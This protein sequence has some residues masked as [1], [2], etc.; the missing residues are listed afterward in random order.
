MRTA[1]RSTTNTRTTARRASSMPPQVCPQSLAIMQC[2]PAHHCHLIRLTRP[3]ASHAHPS[4]HYKA[5]LETC[6]VCCCLTPAAQHFDPYSYTV[7]YPTYPA[8]G[9]V[10]MVPQPMPLGYDPYADQLSADMSRVS[11]SPSLDSQDGD[12]QAGT[13]QL[14]APP[15]HW[16]SPSFLPFQAPLSL[17]P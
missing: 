1:V 7:P 16:A 6:A 17:L 14:P 3:L 5:H 8:Y 13:S 11:L 4:C 2:G 12:H 15:C 10:P 9:F